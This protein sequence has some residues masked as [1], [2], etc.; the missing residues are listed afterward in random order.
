[1]IDI[2]PYQ[3]VLLAGACG[4][5]VIIWQNWLSFRDTRID[6]E[7]RLRERLKGRGDTEGKIG[8]SVD[9]I[10]IH[11][12]SRVSKLKWYLGRGIDSSVEVKI[13]SNLNFDESVW[14]K[15]EKMFDQT[16]TETELPDVEFLYTHQSPD[17]QTSLSVL[18]IDSTDE[19]EIMQVVCGVPRIVDMMDLKFEPDMDQSPVPFDLPDGYEENLTGAM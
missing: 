15:V 14:N 18:R 12:L 19:S 2:N 1:M 6:L 9:E 7:N 13:E 8:V 11:K 16:Q 10:R 5:F 4:T 17:S 3:L